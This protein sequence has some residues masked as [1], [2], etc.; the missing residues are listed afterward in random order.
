M[1]SEEQDTAYEM[2]SIITNMALWLSKHAAYVA[3]VKAEP[4]EAEA[5]EVHRCLRMA[6]GQ[7]QFVQMHLV[8]RLLKSDQKMGNGVQH[9]KK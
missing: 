4:T 1:N 2:L 8:D 6:A 5:K 7:F 9:T 3:A